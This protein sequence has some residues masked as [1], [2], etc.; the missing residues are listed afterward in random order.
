MPIDRKRYPKDWDEL[1][2]QAKVKADWKCQYCGLQCLRPEDDRSHL[3]KSQITKL[4][5][6]TH[7]TSFLPE[8]REGLICCCCD[9]HLKIHRRG[10]GSCSPGQLS[11]PL[12]I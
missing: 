7:H 11:L 10:K 9:C 2:Y 6:Q 5:L 12:A 8:D 4:T 1:A 3:T